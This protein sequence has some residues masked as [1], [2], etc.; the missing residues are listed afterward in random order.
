M[1]YKYLLPT[2]EDMIEPQ[3]EKEW[4]SREDAYDFLLKNLEMEYEPTESV[5][6]GGSSAIPHLFEQLLV[7]NEAFFDKKHKEH[8]RAVAEWR[9]VLI[10]MALKRIKNIKLDLVKVDLTGNTKNPFL[11]AAAQFKPERDPLFEKTTWDFTY[12]LLMG[13]KPI[14]FFS[15]D[16]IVCPAKMFKKRISSLNWISLEKVN[17]KEE[18]LL[19][20]EK[21]GNEY[22]NI[23]GW[24]EQVKGNLREYNRG[25]GSKDKINTVVEEI[26]FMIRDYN[27]KIAQ[28]FQFKLKENI[29]SDMN[30]NIRKEY[31]FLNN[32]GDFTNNSKKMEFLVEKH[33]EDIFYEKLLLLIY[34][35]RSDSMYDRGNIVRLHQLV[36]RVVELD[37]RMLI[38]V[39]DSGGEEM[40]FF[41]FLPFRKSF[42]KELIVHGITAEELFDEFRFIYIRGKESV[43]LKMTIKGFPYSFTKEYRIADCQ[44]I[45]SKDLSSVYLWPGEVARNNEWDAY[46]MYVSRYN[47][48]MEVH[49]AYP[50]IF[51]RIYESRTCEG[52]FRKVFQMLHS[53]VF[54]DYIGIGFQNVSGY[55]PLQLSVDSQRENGATA[56]IYMDVGHSCTYVSTIRTKEEKKPE[57]ICFQKPKSIHIIKNPAEDL[58]VKYN[59]VEPEENYIDVEEE[60]GK[61]FKNVINCFSD[62]T[63]H[64]EDYSME[65]FKDGQTLFTNDF[66]KSG[67][68]DGIASFIRMEYASMNENSRRQVHV[69]LEQILTYAV[70]T[71]VSAGCD[72]FVV[73]FLHKMEPGTRC[74][75]ELKGLWLDAL[76]K[77]TKRIGVRKVIMESPI[78]C[79]CEYEALAYS[80][81]QRLMENKKIDYCH[82]IFP[83]DQIC[84]SA[85][86]GWDK[87]TV[88]H[89]MQGEEGRV[90]V[91]HCSLDFA[92]QNISLVNKEIK[93]D[94]YK[95]ILSALLSQPYS[96]GRD[97]EVKWLL[98]EFGKLYDDSAKNPDYYYGIFDL[99]AMK[100]END[101]FRIFPDIYNKKEEFKNYIKMLTYNMGLLFFEIGIFIGMCENDS[102]QR[103]N[104]IDIYLSG[105][106]TKFFYWIANLKK[107]RIVQEDG[108][109]EMFIVKSERTVLEMVKLG[110]AVGRRETA[111][112]EMQCS[113]Y[114]SDNPKETLLEGYIIHEN[115]S[116]SGITG[117]APEFRFEVLNEDEPYLSKEQIETVIEDLYI[118]IFNEGNVRDIEQP[119]E[120]QNLF[121]QDVTRIICENSQRIC[122]ETAQKIDGKKD[123]TNS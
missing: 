21:N 35:D 99:I 59:F 20:F 90:S 27:G 107:N 38:A 113:I 92:G 49:L 71:S 120:G 22:A 78:D 87:T 18:L 13:E 65:P 115:P 84:I 63:Y 47:P 97:S 52:K 123:G 8:Q 88:L 118:D 105:N 5:F 95:N 82:P 75:G 108:K 4:E 17:Q 33:P 44:K 110:V 76:S 11:K 69:F 34:E 12:I 37:G 122:T 117:E 86:I 7:F 6:D 98:D 45:Y 100:I 62:Y 103:K 31:D 89:M 66:Y 28:E 39:T 94:K 46:Y 83:D 73:K 56:T 93:F 3:S 53:T 64:P 41:A 80:L 101:D 51:E 114:L 10:I 121:L 106:G 55:L 40:P 32:C 54:P 72:Y 91:R 67:L 70:Q 116:L 2:L 26:N 119:Q 23:K 96:M 15:P 1:A 36:N 24:V 9:A 42:V 19:S 111:N 68:K 60:K 81:Y 109:R 61:Y 79:C 29:Y 50:Q 43:E 25:A 30:H 57:R 112:Y 85:D 16:T 58:S 77:V 48:D 102:D 74:L 14:A 104:K